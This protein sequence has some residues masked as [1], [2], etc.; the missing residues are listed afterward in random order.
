MIGVPAA[1]ESHQQRFLRFVEAAQ[2]EAVAGGRIG[3]AG[4]IAQL[5]PELLL[6][7]ADGGGFVCGL[8]GGL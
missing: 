2:A 7:R 5:L 6:P 4:E 1:G 3:A 8:C